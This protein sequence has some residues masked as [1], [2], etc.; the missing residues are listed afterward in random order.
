MADVVAAQVAAEAEVA[1]VHA[2]AKEA[3]TATQAEAEK[4]IEDEFGAS[5][6]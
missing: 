1:T 2:E 4:T 6:F 3:V 5:F